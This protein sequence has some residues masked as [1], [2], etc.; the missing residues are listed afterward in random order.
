MKKQFTYSSKIPKRADA[1]TRELFPHLSR[2]LIND[3]FRKDRVR[4]NGRVCSKGAK[5]KYGD[6]VDFD[7]FPASKDISLKP[8]PEIE[9]E[10]IKEDKY[11]IAVNKPSGLPS[12]PIDHREKKTLANALAAKIE[13]FTNIGGKPLEGG[14]VHRLDN[15]TSGLILAAK[16]ADSF[17]RFRDIF[18]KKLISKT[19]L[20]LVLGSVGKKG[21]VSSSLEHHP[22]NKKKMKA[23]SSGMQCK[24]NYAL[25]RKYKG[26]SL[27]RIS[28]KTAVR[29]Q[30][31]IHMASIEHP[32]AGDALYQSKGQQKIDCLPIRGH[33][34]HAESVRFKHPFTK[35]TVSISCRM[36][37]Q[38]EKLLK[39]LPK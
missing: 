32:L 31:R 18:K 33:F 17:K 8:N 20:A 7:S 34:L 25:I 29:H 10:V 16:T 38:L 35:K 24:T 4:I 11:F 2:T 26:Y 9:L 37:K 39:K 28:L 19:Y 23:V 12:H 22:T 13:N 14:L 36:P 15:D 27:I 30:I 3:L 5:L 21:E 1:F 6:S